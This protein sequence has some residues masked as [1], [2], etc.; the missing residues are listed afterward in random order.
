MT[1]PLVTKEQALALKELGFDCFV[2]NHYTEKN[3]HTECDLIDYN[4][5]KG[6]ISVPTISLALRFMRERY[7]WLLIVEPIG[8]KIDFPVFMFECVNLTNY[9]HR[10]QTELTRLK[11]DYELL[12]AYSFKSYDEAESAGL[13]KLIEIAKQNSN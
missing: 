8:D 2:R 11:M 13:D 4:K 7:D 9:M 1:E 5:L 10:T 12:I 6:L 3:L